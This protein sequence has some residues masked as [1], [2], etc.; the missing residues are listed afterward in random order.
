MQTSIKTG[1]GSRMVRAKKGVSHRNTVAD[2]M[3]NKTYPLKLFEATS[4]EVRSYLRLAPDG[5]VIS[6]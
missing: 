3:Y 1:K 2:S 5:T 4:R 6:I